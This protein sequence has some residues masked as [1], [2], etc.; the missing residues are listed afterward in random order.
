MAAYFDGSQKGTAFPMVTPLEDLS[1]DLQ[2]RIAAELEEAE[3]TGI[4]PKKWL[5]LSG[6]LA[7]IRSRAYYEWRKAHKSA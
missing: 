5:T 1:P 3:R 7:Q 6:G 4:P 2:L